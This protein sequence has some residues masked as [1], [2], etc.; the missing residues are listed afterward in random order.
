ME[1]GPQ[2]RREFTR[3]PFR[4]TITVRTPERTIWSSS[5]ADVSMTGLRISTSEP[6]PPQG[7]ACEIEIA[8]GSEDDP[9]VIAGRGEI[10]RSEP[11]SIAVHVTEIDVD[12]YTHLARLI[13]NNAGDAE[14]IEEEIRSHRGIRRPS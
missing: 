3:V 10:V 6:P 11:G 9:V 13:L 1:A 14:R 12:S 5:T 8:L 2:D 4:T 7:S